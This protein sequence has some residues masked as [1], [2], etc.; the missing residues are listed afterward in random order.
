MELKKTSV[1][2]TQPMLFQGGNLI[3]MIYS[4]N[5]N[6]NKQEKRKE[7]TLKTFY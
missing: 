4:S 2:L 1:T 7:K 5:T 3:F 6:L